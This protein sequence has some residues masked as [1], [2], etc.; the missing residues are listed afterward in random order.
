MAVDATTP[1]TRRAIL[2]GGLAAAAA[3]S[4]GRA[5]AASAHDPEDVQAGVT[6]STTNTTTIWNTADGGSGI[7]GDA[8]G[9]GTGV[10]GQ[11]DS[12]RGVTGT[13]STGAGVVGTSQDDYGV[14]GSSISSNG[15]RG[16][17][18]NF[19]GVYGRAFAAGQS[20]VY[21][22]ASLGRGGTFAGKLAQIQLKPSTA[23]T[24]P[25]SGVRG[26]F[27]VDHSGRLWFC[28]GGT[29]WKQLA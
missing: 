25:S 13:S 29:T 22:Q 1:R 8:T 7:E 17:S 20:G 15:V 16:D 14:W 23:A 18:T 21:G 27:F 19:I 24:H 10:A 26:D 2:A 4:L 3:A 6:N 28:K 11:S 5:Q 9:S 12:G